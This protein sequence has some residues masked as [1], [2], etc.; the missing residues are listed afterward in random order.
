MNRRCMKPGLLLGVLL[1]TLASAASAQTWAFTVLLDDEPI[2]QHRFVLAPADD[3]TRE[4]RSEA[5]F[6][7]RLLGVPV[8]RYRHEAK[9]R[10]RGDC[11]QSMQAWTLDGRERSEVDARMAQGALLVQAGQTEEKVEG[12]LMSFAYW[13]PAIQRQTRLL[14][15]QTGKMEQVRL[16]RSASADID[17]RGQRLTAERWRLSGTERPLDVWW[18]ADGQWVG[19]DATVRGGRKLSYRLR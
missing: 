9:E 10:W 19:L 17:V 2:G 4:L 7:V 15:A 13:N 11:L 16:V 12:C 14:N 1:S 5:D 3:G 6:Q 8:Y 18:T